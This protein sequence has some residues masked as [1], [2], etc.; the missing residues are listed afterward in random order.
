MSP[1]SGKKLN[2]TGFSHFVVSPNFFS[3]EFVVVAD[4]HSCSA[5]VGTALI[6]LGIGAVTFMV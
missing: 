6:L 3:S 2:S 1:V 5:S 4:G